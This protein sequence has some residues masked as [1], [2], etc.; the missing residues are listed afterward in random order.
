[1]KVLVCTDFSAASAAG[2]REAGERFRD[3]TLIVFHA[4]DEDLVR[5]VKERTGLDPERLREDMMNLADTRVEEI[6][7][8]LRSQGRRA[9]ADIRTGSPPELALQVAAQ[10]EARLIVLGVEAGVAVGR[11]RVA[12]VRQ[13]RIPLLVIPA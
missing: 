3:A 7:Q 8:R 5:R 6:L 9:S 4:V 2:E 13:S 1:M 10:H 11:F 12:L